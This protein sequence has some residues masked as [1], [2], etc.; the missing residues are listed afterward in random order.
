MCIIVKSQQVT[1]VDS[2]DNKPIPYTK[3]ISSENLFLTDSLGVYNFEKF[4]TEEVSVHSAGYEIKKLK[5]NSEIIQL[6][7][8]INNIDNIVISKNNFDNDKELGFN[9]DKNSIILNSKVEFAIEIKNT[10]DN[11]CRI[12]KVKIPFK[13][14]LNKKGY[15]LF[16]FYNSIE[17][18]IEK[19]INMLNYVFPVSFLE[20]NNM[21]T[22]KEKIYIED[23]GSIYISVIWVENTYSKSETF[24]NKIYFFTKQQKPFGKMFVRKSNY[25]GWNLKPYFEDGQTKNSI[26]PAFKVLSKCG[27]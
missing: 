26:I 20:A 1:I 17:G 11:T 6:T 15:L 3:I 4:P 24:D 19:K 2:L 16:D 5:L 13:K 12:E 21:V 23:Q 18:K 22:L 8:K 9:A 25:E 7:P 27:N 10:N 14:S